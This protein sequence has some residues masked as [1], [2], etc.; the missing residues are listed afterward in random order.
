M[1]F[2]D[3][4]LV[5]DV[6]DGLQASARKKLCVEIGRKIAEMHDKNIIHGDLTTSNLL[7]KD[8]VYFIDFG[9][10]FISERVED[11]AVDLHLLRQALDGKHY[12][13]A[14]ECFDFVL[15]GYKEYD[16]YEKVFKQL[17]KVEM[18]GRYK[19]KNGTV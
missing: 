5:K 2:I 13:I 7:L 9:L 17:R 19:R 4:E 18:R 14:E 1:I 16:G 10:G 12:L 6:L 3:G 11:K 8:K 15:D